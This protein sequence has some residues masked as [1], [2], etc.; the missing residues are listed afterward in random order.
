MREGNLMSAQ[1]VK[2]KL[3]A[4]LS[5]DVKGYSRLMAEDEVATVQTLTAY[6]EVM[7]SL[8]QQHRGRVVDSPGD[9]LL[10]EFS[11]VVDAVQ[12][13]VAVQKEFQAR[14]AELPEERRM[15]FRIGINLGDVIEEGERIYGDGVN[16]AARLEALAD[17]GGICVSKTAFDHIETKL[18]FGYEYLGDQTVKNIPKP[19][20]AYR[21]LMEPRVVVAGEKEKGPLVPLLRRKTVLVGSLAVLVVI[22]GLLVWNFYF[23]APRI[24]PASV[25]RMA[26]PLPEK[27]SIAVLPF[28]NMSG[29]SKQ[30]YLANGMTENIIN[31][32]SKISEIFVIACQSAFSYKGKPVK[33]QQVSEELGVRHV[34]EGSIQRSGDRVRIT[35][36]LV[37]ATTGR[38]L[39]SEQ[40]DREMK[41]IFALQDEITHEI[42]VA[43]Q[44]KLTE[45]EQALVR[46]RSTKNLQAWGYAVRGYSLMQRYTK[47]DNAKARELLEQAVK[48]DPEYA[49]A[50]TF[51]AWTHWI[52][53]RFRFSKSRTESFKRAAELAE[54]A[55]A[56]DDKDPDV[57]ALLARIHLFQRQHEKAIAEGEKSVALGPNNAE[58]IVILAM[59]LK[60][61]GRF[62][63]AIELAKKGMRLHPSH[64]PWYL[65]NVSTPAWFLGRYEEA[66]A[67]TKEL[68]DRQRKAGGPHF[69]GALLQ[70]ASIYGELGRVEEAKPLLEEVLKQRP[71]LTL[72]R[73]RKGYEKSNFYKDPIYVERAMEAIRKAGLK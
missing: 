47:E 67:T 30:E 69:R 61:A 56:M 63:E 10:A 13:A 16:I 62:E 54:K 22:G 11:S 12:C 59:I 33:V 44:V 42:V 72:V 9:N 43:L 53:A 26:F 2:R 8:I 39:W 55:V 57:H 28:V 40:Y 66:I 17:P 70:L 35:A 68:I 19:V 15:E 27:P 1:G 37:D 21:V 24:E 50:W 6:R 58:N 41:E 71:N 7:T 46:H 29:D 48:L 52:D 36:Q 25:E 51:L 38:H 60:F 31:A 64:P 4:I 20:G 3:S 45:G 73:R 23:R 32:L 65:W 5:A 49:W 14:N 18:P 34:L